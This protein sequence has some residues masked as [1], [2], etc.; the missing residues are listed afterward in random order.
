MTERLYHFTRQGYVDSILREGIT[1]GDVPTS[2]MGG[3]Q[4]PWLTDDPN[5]GKQGW[6]QGGDKTQMRLTVDIPD[7][8]E[9]SEG[10]TYSPLDYLWR[11]RDLAEVEDVE[12]WWF[13]SLDEAAGGG[14]EHWYVYKGPEG[15]RPEWISIVEDRTG[16]MMV[17]GE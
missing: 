6:V 11:W 10:Q 1:R 7:T 15:I 17:R 14:S 12:V 3:Y 9:D 8:W 13:E 16:N 2:P 5:A 4:A